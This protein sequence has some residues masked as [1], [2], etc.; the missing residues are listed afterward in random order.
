MA[1]LL[2]IRSL[3]FLICLSPFLWL[4]YGFF[5]GHLGVNPIE[6]LVRELGIWTLRFLLLTLAV[7]S[8]FRLTHYAPLMTYRRMIGLY[9]FF[10][11]LMHLSAYIGLDHFFDWQTLW[12]DI[13]KRPYITIGMSALILLI[14]LAATSPKA[15][16]KKL[17]AKRWK[18]LHKLIYPIAILGVV[19]FY[20]LVKADVREPLI[21]GGLLGLLLVERFYRHRQ[22]LKRRKDRKRAKHATALDPVLIQK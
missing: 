9:A 8:V 20:L 1:P 15:M 21:Y 19:H 10:Y 16:L 18:K 17:G 6:A 5:N 3:V 11:A 2:S 13:V 7:S 22:T 4:L 12:K 14:P